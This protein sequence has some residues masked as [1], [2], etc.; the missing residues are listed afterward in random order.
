M[1]IVVGQSRSAFFEQ[2]HDA[3]SGASDG[4]ASTIAR[5]FSDKQSR[6]QT[7][8]TRSLLRA[9][10]A[11]YGH[12]VEQLREGRCVT[13]LMCTS[14]RY[15]FLDPPANTQLKTSG[16]TIAILQGGYDL[17]GFELRRPKTFD[18]Y[19]PPINAK[20]ACDRR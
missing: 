5:F 18:R 7:Q 1:W 12:I 11:S 10:S 14:A 4:D 15:G 20:A 2:F 9:L 17:H 13:M 16:C 19:Y 8:G 3:E 6:V